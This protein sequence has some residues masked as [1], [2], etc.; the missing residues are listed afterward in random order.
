M[1]AQA[2]LE[3]QANGGDPDEAAVEAADILRQCKEML[4][5][6]VEMNP[7]GHCLYAAVADQ[8]NLKQPAPQ[9]YDYSAVRSAAAAYMRA[10]REDFLPFLAEIDDVGADSDADRHAQFMKYCDAIEHTSEWGG[11]PEIVALSRVLHTPIHVV[12]SGSSVIKTGDEDPMREPLLISCVAADSVTHRSY[13][14]KMYGLGEV[15]ARGGYSSSALQLAPAYNVDSN[16]TAAARGLVSLA[17][18]F[19]RPP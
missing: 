4:L 7:D 1:R 10:H 3:L 9:A 6:M 12:Q 17:L 13:H 11:Q 5:T 14:R 19:R 18:M 8:L 15:R 2:E 16:A